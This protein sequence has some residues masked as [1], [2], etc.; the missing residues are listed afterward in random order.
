MKAAQYKSYGTPEVIEVIDSAQPQVKDNQVLVEV[1]AAS[2]NPIDW[3][4]REGYLKEMMPLHFPVTIGGNFSG[5]VT[6]VGKNVTKFKKGDEVYG[7]SL[8]LNGGSGSVAE[9]TASNEGNTALKPSNIDHPHAAALPLV[10]VSALQALEQHI[11][12]QSGQ[13][14]LITGGAG[15]IGSLAIQ[16]A[17]SIGAYVASTATEDGIEY[18]AKMGADEVVD[19]KNEKVEEK[20]HEYDAIFDTVGGDSATTAMKILKKGGIIVSMVGQ[21]DPK[22]A[23]E[24]GVTSFGQNTDTSTKNLER[25]IELVEK[26][27]IKV[28]I[29]KTFPIE[30]TKEAFVYAETGHPRGKVVITLK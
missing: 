5:V 21:P 9:F 28:E 2:L 16:L 11:R 12:L 14:I 8:V 30:K 1:F 25:I 24:L 4:V 10:G 6:E 18:A 19:Y 22:L 26:E 13:K 17:K 29:D 23:Q 20:L 7:Q 15:G 27:I 3:K